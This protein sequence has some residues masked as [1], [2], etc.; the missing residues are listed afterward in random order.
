MEIE[1]MIGRN[2]IECVELDQL[3][4]GNQAP[5]IRPHVE[6]RLPQVDID[7]LDDSFQQFVQSSMATPLVLRY[8][9]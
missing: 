5:D 3:L 9:Q 6:Q 4:P 2:T 1:G 7:A 8:P